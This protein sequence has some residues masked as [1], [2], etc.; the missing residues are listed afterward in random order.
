MSKLKYVGSQIIMDDLINSKFDKKVFDDTI[1]NACNDLWEL[2]QKN[3]L[4]NYDL[5]MKPRIKMR[6]LINFEEYSEVKS[7]HN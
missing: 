4:E 7:G 2:V 5:I 1:Y 6:I 3:F